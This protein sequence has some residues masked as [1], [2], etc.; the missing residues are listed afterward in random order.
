[1]IFPAFQ[2]KQLF[3][4][5]GRKSKKQ[6]TIEQTFKILKWIKCNMYSLQMFS[7]CE[8]AYI[9]EAKKLPKF[10]SEIVI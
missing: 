1:M 6:S 4:Q 3:W 5:L 2:V 7:K 9:S 8:T 10:C